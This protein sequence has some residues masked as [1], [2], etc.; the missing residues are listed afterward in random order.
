M[1]T[2]HLRAGD[3]FILVVLALLMSSVIYVVVLAALTPRRSVTGKLSRRVATG[4][5]V[6]ELGG[7]FANM[8]GPASWN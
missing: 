5:V 3:V 8:R 1:V 7:R 6:R 4:I 2:A